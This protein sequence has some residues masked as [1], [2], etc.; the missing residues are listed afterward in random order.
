MSRTHDEQCTKAAN[1]P[2]RERPRC[3]FPYRVL[4]TG[5]G[6]ASR[7]DPREALA[8]L[9]SRPGHGSGRPR[10]TLY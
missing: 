4:G 2:R 3:T 7:Y 8:F 10:R 6:A 1:D 9:A 5:R